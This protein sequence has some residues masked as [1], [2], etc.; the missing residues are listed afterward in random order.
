MKPI[1]DSELERGQILWLNGY[2]QNKHSHERLVLL[3]IE[4]SHYG[5]WY[6]CVNVDKLTMRRVD[7]V[8]PESELFGIGIYYTPG[9]MFDRLEDIGLF[10]ECAIENEKLIKMEAEEEAKQKSINRAKMVEEYKSKYTFLELAKGS[11]KSGHALGASNLRKELKRQFPGVT[12]SITS[13]SYSGGNSIDVRWT[14]GPLTADVD[15]I[16]DRYQEC[17]FNGMEDLETCRNSVFPGLFCGAHYVQTQRDVT[18]QRYIDKAL[19]MGYTVTI[20][21]NWNWS[22]DYPTREMIQRATWATA[23]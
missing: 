12:F 16:A 21:S 19:E 2:G 5:T 13:K 15:K 1:T 10:I 7:H 6:R 3:N 17:D 4:R 22:C 20:D 8:R 18:T 9:D 23:F 14:D 11:K